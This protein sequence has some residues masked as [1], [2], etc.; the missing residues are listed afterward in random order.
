MYPVKR[1]A[2][3]LGGARSDLVER[4]GGKRPKRGPQT[5]APEDAEL[6]S[7]IR[8]LLDSSPSYGYRRIAPLLVRER[9]SPRPRSSQ[10]QST[11]TGFMKRLVAGPALQGAASHGGVLGHQ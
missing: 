3:P 6:T 2:E 4:A 5:P 9:R 1:I 8:C 11:S 10:R 7:D